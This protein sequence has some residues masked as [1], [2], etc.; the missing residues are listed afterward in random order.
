MELCYRQDNNGKELIVEKLHKN[1]RIMKHTLKFLAAGLVLVATSLTISAQTTYNIENGIATAKRVDQNDDGT[2]KVHLETYATGESTTFSTSKPSD[3][4]LV[5]DVSTSMVNNRYPVGSQTTRLAALKTAASNFVDI[6]YSKAREARQTD[7]GFDGNRI[8]IVSFG[9]WVTDNTNGWKDV[10]ENQTSL[11]STINGLTTGN[12][13]TWTSSGLRVAIENY[14]DGNPRSAREDANLTVVLFTDGE[15]TVV[16][17]QTVDGQRVTQ[18]TT[19]HPYIANNSVYYSHLM[20]STYNAKVFTV[21][22]LGNNPDN[23]VIPLAELI[24]SNYPD[25]NATFQ[26]SNAWTYNSSTGRVSATGLS[27]GDP[28]NDGIAYHQNVGQQDLN[29]I[30]EAIAESAGSAEAEVGSSTQVR[31]V[32]SNSFTLPDNVKP[33]D[34]SVSIWSINPD[35]IGWTEDSEYDTS[36]ITPVVGTNNSGN[37]TVTVEGFDY[38]KD[39]E[40]EGRGDGNWV[41]VRIPD[42]RDLTQN[43]YAGRKL[44]IEFNVEVR[45]GVTGGDTQ[46][47]TSESG[48][49]VYNAETQQYECKNYYDVPEKQLPINIKIT[50]TG[51]RHGESATFEIFKIGPQTND[52]GSIVY[53]ALGKPVPNENGST[54]TDPEERGWAEWSKVILTNLGADG[55]KVEKTLKNLNP[56]YV[57][58]VLEDD[59]SWSYTTTGSTSGVQSTSSVTVN[60]FSFKNEEKTTAVKHAEAVMINH[61][62]T[63]EEGEASTQHGKSSKVESF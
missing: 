3:I 11:K 35:G 56:N 10:E 20:K 31:D 38:S 23:R 7:E 19:F 49:Y 8:A 52:D 44:V 25:A 50:K 62:A 14:L 24:S 54:S 48:V 13:G 26:S 42:P 16:G 46:T 33:A 2:Y 5:L 51:L 15:P 1:I 41:G 18:N 21:T 60:P 58:L 28:N 61:F 40:E 12:S 27:Y 53:N 34:V 57:Y 43:F 4:I 63:S 30:F 59:W 36:D 32:V 22:L 45:E 6:V 37:S 9:G 17:T 47:N 29:S 39:D 55:A